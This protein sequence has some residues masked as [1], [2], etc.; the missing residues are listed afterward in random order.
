MPPNARKTTLLHHSADV[1][2][3]LLILGRWFESSSGSQLKDEAGQVLNL[4][5]F[6]VSGASENFWDKTGTDLG[7]HRNLASPCLTECYPCPT[8]HLSQPDPLC[9]Q[10]LIAE[11]LHQISHAATK[12]T[13]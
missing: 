6:V 1:G 4:T 5:G 13:T 9:G 12:V 7:Q 11:M 8:C 2:K 3:E 10:I